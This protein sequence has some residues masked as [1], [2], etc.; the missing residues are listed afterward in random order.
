MPRLSDAM[1]AK[2]TCPAGKRDALFFDDQV[3]GLAVRITAAGSKSFLFQYTWAG[4]K[5]RLPLGSWGRITLRQAREAAA[6]A[7]GELAQH[8]DP[9]AKI[10]AARA[11]SARAATTLEAMVQGWHDIGLRHASDRHRHEAPRALRTAFAR[12]LGKPAVG[13][14]RRRALQVLDAMAK[15]GKATMAARTLAYGRACYAW[16]IRREIVDSNPFQ[17]LP[18]DAA[19]ATRDRVLDDGEVGAIY[20]AAGAMGRPFGAL[21]RL[22][23]LTGQR[24]DEVAKLRWS[25]LDLAG[26]LWTIPASRAKNGKAHDVHLSEPALAILNGL[27][28]VLD[29][30]GQPSDLV[31][32][33]NG[34]TAVSGY[35]NA[36]RRLRQLADAQRVAWGQPPLEPWVLHDF[37]RSVVTWAAQ[38][39]FNPAV[40]DRILNHQTSSTMTV[41]AQV[42]Q[43]AQFLPE[44][45]RVL[46]AWGAH[47]VRQAGGP[48]A[49]VPGNVVSLGVR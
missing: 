35:T 28:V 15:D 21:F 8:R 46:D 49:A 16:A 43:R 6:A 30:D 1:L 38:A 17:N 4:R 31:F 7:A 5:Q 14:N 34:R 45:K 42:Y 47:V 25:E 27:D 23:L 32:T 13:L 48:A 41:V 24:R 2:L 29:A 10:E 37:R 19:T 40:A 39:G 22:L 11:D 33:T 20:A 3:K 44:R 26:G 9:K 12:D 18:I 36:T